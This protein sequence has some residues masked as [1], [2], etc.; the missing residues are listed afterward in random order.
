MPKPCP[1]KSHDA[2]QQDGRSNV[3]CLHPGFA[4][5]LHK[6]PLRPHED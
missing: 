4:P 6:I 5:G 1:R 2:A 3:L